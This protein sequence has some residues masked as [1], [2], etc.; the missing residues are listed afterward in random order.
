MCSSDLE[1]GYENATVDYVMSVIESASKM[2]PCVI[3]YG[4][5]AQTVFPMLEWSVLKHRNMRNKACGGGVGTEK[6]RD[7]MV[8]IIK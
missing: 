8:A 1:G 5:D 7:D 4:N 6:E 2:G 3:T